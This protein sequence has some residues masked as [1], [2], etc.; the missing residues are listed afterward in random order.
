M[1][2]KLDFIKESRMAKDKGKTL[3]IRVEKKKAKKQKKEVKISFRRA[4]QKDVNL[5]SYFHF[6]FVYR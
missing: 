4:W 1:L 3:K 5:I 2:V 6:T